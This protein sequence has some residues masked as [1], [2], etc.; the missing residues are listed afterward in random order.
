MNF[1]LRKLKVEQPVWRNNWGISPS[2]ALDKPLYA[3]ALAQDELTMSADGVTSETIKS[4]FLEVEYQTIR[5]LPK[6]K[7]ILFT[8]NTMAEPFYGLEKV[9]MAASCLAASIR[10]MGPDMLAYKG[11]D[12]EAVCKKVLK[13]LDSIGTSDANVTSQ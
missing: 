2:Y 12:S 3:S 4:K 10:G 13:Y 8:V 11:I 1:S 9:P 5:R 6:S 7:Y